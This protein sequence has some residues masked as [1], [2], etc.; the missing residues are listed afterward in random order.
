MRFTYDAYS[1]LLDLGTEK[2]YAY[3]TYNN[4][5]NYD[6]TIILRHDVDISPSAVTK[7]AK[8]EAEKGITSTYF[9]LI[10]S[11]FYNILSVENQKVV[12]NIINSGH[13]I[14]LH[15]DEKAHDK[16]KNIEESIAY[17]KQILEK[18]LGITIDVV[19]M[20]RPSQETLERDYI[21]A[22]IINSYGSAF[23]KDMHYVSDSRRNWREDIL[24]EIEQESFDRFHVLTH[25]IWYHE[26]EE[27]L[28]NMLKNFIG[29]AEEERKNILRENIRDFDEIFK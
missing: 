3:C 4:W 8:I 2:G 29:Q 22:D 1:Q 24:A 21:F 15:F 28:E 7:F 9:F 23:F 10:T 5:L 26:E 14:G 18:D 17:E 12:Q 16:K 19:S 27:S 11:P 20:H 25:P 13:R 6:K